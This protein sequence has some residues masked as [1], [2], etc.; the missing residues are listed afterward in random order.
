MAEPRQDLFNV[1]RGSAVVQERKGSYAV[2]IPREV[3]ESLGVTKGD[4][5]EFA[6]HQDGQPALLRPSGDD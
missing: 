6:H 2:T 1:A 3:A 5:V 4:E